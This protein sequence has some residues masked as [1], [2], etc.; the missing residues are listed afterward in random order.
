MEYITRPWHGVY[1]KAMAWPRFFCS[2]QVLSLWRYSILG[3]GHILNAATRGI[4]PDNSDQIIKAEAGPELG[5]DMISSC[6]LSA[7]LKT[8]F[9]T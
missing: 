3:L 2:E 4:P 9:T 6:C 7:K 1:A 5:N 8:I